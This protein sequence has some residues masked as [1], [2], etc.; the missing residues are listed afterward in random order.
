MQFPFNR[1]S[2]EAMDVDN[3]DDDTTEMDIDIWYWIV[4]IYMK[5]IKGLTIYDSI[6]IP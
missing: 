5:W 6:A 3:N 4:R 2:S 1:P